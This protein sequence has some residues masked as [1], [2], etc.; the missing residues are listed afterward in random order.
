[1]IS[2]EKLMEMF[3]DVK[4]SRTDIKWLKTEA[5]RRNGILEEHVKDS[6][7]YRHAIIR[8]TAWRHA[9]KIAIGMLFTIICWALLKGRITP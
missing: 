8:N 6:E 4:A 5:I 2:D 3:G 7:K 9:F 1:M